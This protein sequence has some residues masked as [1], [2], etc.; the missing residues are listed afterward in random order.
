MRVLVADE[1]GAADEAC[2][3]DGAFRAFLEQRRIPY[4]VAVRASQSVLPRP[5]WR[6]VGRLAGRC[7]ADSPPGD[8]HG[9]QLRQRDRAGAPAQEVADGPGIAVAP[10]QQE[11]VPVVVSFGGVVG[12]D[13][14]HRP[15]V[16]L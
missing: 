10:E 11:R 2:G 13:L 5:G 3:C 8:G 6:H 15:V 1:A 16:V 7:A 9:D 4:A 12:R 14:D